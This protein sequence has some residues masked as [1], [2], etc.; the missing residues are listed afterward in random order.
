MSLKGAITRLNST[1][2]TLKDVN[3]RKLTDSLERELG[4]KRALAAELPKIYKRA[5]ASLVPVVRK[6]L[7]QNYKKAGIGIISRELWNKSVM[8]AIVRVNARGTAIIVEMAPGG[9]KETYAAAGAFRFGAVR[10]REFK[11]TYIDLPTGATKTYKGG[12]GGVIGAKAK[13]SI[14]KKI[15]SGKELS[16]RQQKAQDALR[17]NI[18]VIAPKSPFFDLNG[19]IDEI[20][21]AFSEAVQKEINAFLR[22]RKAAA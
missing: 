11:S 6:I 4:S 9:K 18:T 19:N 1:T 8:Q 22:S 14:K 13:R 15:F 7:G 3:V 16:P 21:A 20:Q 5:A 17:K 12:K 10:N 2:R